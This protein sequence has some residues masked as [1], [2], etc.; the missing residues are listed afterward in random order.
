MLTW[1][2]I[3]LLWCP[4]SLLV[5]KIVT[6]TGG[7]ALEGN[8]SK[9]EGPPTLVEVWGSMESQRSAPCLSWRYSV[10]SAIPIT[11][12]EV[13][14]L[15]SSVL[16]LTCFRSKNSSLSLNITMWGMKLLLQNSWKR[17]YIVCY[18][19]PKGGLFIHFWGGG[20][21]QCKYLYFLNGVQL[22]TLIDQVSGHSVWPK[23][24]DQL[25]TLGL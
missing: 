23:L 6:F 22:L 15:A 16:T 13:F 14:P 7:L 10:S 20:G 12:S 24:C 5:D 21:M 25:Q 3:F 18:I 2:C 8:E 19:Y 17:K 9:L 4:L 11:R 1:S